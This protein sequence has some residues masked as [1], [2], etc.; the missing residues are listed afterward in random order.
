MKQQLRQRQ[1]WPE[2][3][4]PIDKGD[5]MTANG[6]RRDFKPLELLSNDQVEA[7]HNATLRVMNETG[8]TFEDEKARSLLADNGCEVD[9]ETQ[10]VR[11]PFSLV[12][13]CLSKA[14]GHYTV[15]ARNRKNDIYLEADG[16]VTYFGPSC[17]MQYLDLKTLEPREPTR[18]EF[19]DTIR[20]ME[21]LPYAHSQLAFP[22]WGFEKVPQA[23]RLIESAAAK[24]RASGKMQFE[25]T[26]QQNDRWIIEMANATGQEI[27]LLCNPTAPLTYQKNTIKQI[28]DYAEG[29]IPFS[30]TSGPLAGS[31][32]PVTTAGA[33]V[34]NN[35]ETFAGIVL[36]QLIKPGSRVWAGHM[37][38][39]QNMQ[40]GGPAFGAIENAL[41]EA[42]FHQML[43]RYNIPG[44]SAAPAWTSS[45]TLDGQAV[46]ETSMAALVCALAGSC[47]VALLGGMTGELSANPVK[48]ILDHDIAGMIG[49]FLRGVEVSEN[50][51]AVD[52][53]HEVGPLPGQFLSTN[54]T[55][56]WWKKEQFIPMIADRMPFPQWAQAGKK[57]VVARAQEKMDQIL[58]EHRID[59]LPSDQEE[60]IERI[61]Y[62]ARQWYRKNEMITDEEW[63]L[64]QEDL[65]SPNYPFA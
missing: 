37:I 8:L 3:S 12:E 42:I 20:L 39:A 41:S 61:L 1:N 14:P 44:Y 63:A 4:Y 33:V 47:Y 56:E 18:K 38:H 10:R 21:A 43:R 5:K 16:D 49:R 15:K 59:P 54:H 17:G 13:D 24:I 52:V 57:D 51:M 50:T 23:L 48:A 55:R 34:A 65:A 22:Y 9:N 53:I 31:T 46:Y 64:Y 11:F 27:V 45:K 6:F 60:T 32:A 28:F 19:Y 25:G 2:A 26:V 29:N 7:I 30:L 62:D 35:A 58:A 40:T 36:A